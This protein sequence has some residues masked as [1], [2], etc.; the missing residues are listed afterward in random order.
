[1]LFNREKMKNETVISVAGVS[2]KYKLY[3]SN[4]LRVL[5]ALWP[6][7]RKLHTE[8]YALKNINLEVNK[9]E[10]LGIIGRN[11]SGKSS[12]LK[13][14]SGIVTP[15]TGKVQVRGKIVPLLELGSGLHPDFTGIE[16]I[17][18]YTALLGFSRQEIER[19]IDPIVEFADIG[20]HIHQ[21]LRTY[22]SGMRA[23]LAFAVSIS[24]DP[25]ILILD[26]VLSVGDGAFNKKSNEKIMS[27]FREGKTILYVSHS[28]KT[29]REICTRAIILDKGE[30][31]LDGPTGEVMGQYER[32]I[33][34]RRNREQVRNEIKSN[35]ISKS[36]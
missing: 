1:M 36:S 25:E 14:I 22:S 31:I 13:I 3:K 15:T 26:E 23:R 2:K 24:I 4:Q 34:A 9:G 30:I 7:G 8:F 27:F 6:F 21:P 32:M 16:N 35:F 18:F 10:V 12:L 5:E 28:H 33:E 11:G 19:R 20:E 17:Y 29:I